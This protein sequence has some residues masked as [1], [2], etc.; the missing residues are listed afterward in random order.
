LGVPGEEEYRGYGVSSCAT[1][2]GFFFRGKRVVV[3]GGGDVAIE[4]AL[5]LSRLASEVTVIHRRDGLRASKAMQQRALANEKIRFIWDTVV[6]EVLGEDDSVAGVP[7]V[8]GLRTRNMK[9]GHEQRVET[10]ALFVAI[11]HEPNTAIFRGQIPLDERGYAQTVAG[12]VRDH[13]Y[14]QAVPAAGDGC[15][16]AIDAER[17]LEERY[18]EVDHASTTPR[19]EM[20]TAEEQRRAG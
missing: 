19:T 8:T 10:D 15:K 17:W 20:R 7:R 14:R 9:T 5:F 3:V 2:D 13:Q 6:E 11:G 1:C 12:D 18:L 4:E 16:A